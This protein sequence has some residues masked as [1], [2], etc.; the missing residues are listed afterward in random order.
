D[1]FAIRSYIS[2][3]RKQ[4]LSVWDALGSLFSDQVIMPQLTPV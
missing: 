1:F 3:I 2:T 4:G